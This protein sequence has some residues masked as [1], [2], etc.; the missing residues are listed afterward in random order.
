LIRSF[1]CRQTERLFNGKFVKKFG[2]IEEAA[3]RKLAILN[4]AESVA[5]LAAVP[6]NRYEK[7]HGDREGQSSIRINEQW[8]LCF[9]W[10]DA[11]SWEVEIVDYH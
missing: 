4:A 10:R 11:H 5:D 6:G 8:R 3:V 7:S 2:A 1:R 9:E